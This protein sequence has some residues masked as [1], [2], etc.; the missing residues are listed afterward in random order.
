MIQFE[1]KSL[2]MVK[3][4]QK[5]H[6][7]FSDFVPHTIFDEKPALFKV[8]SPSKFLAFPAGKFPAC[9]FPY[10]AGMR[11]IDHPNSEPF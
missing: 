7:I 4:E 2:I 10:R 11:E 6:E 3:E 8:F 9:H 5:L 1:I